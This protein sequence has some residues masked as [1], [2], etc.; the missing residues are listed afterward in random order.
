MKRVIRTDKVPQSPK[1]QSQV[2]S[3]DHFIFLSGH[4]ATDYESGIA[5]EVAVDPN[6]PYC[7]SPPMVRQTGY[8]LRNMGAV[9][10]AAG[11]GFENLIRIEQFMV[12]KDQSPWYPIARRAVMDPQ[13]PTST[14]V[15]A[16]GLE[17]PDAIIVCDGIAINPDSGWKKET[18][19]IDFIPKSITGYPAAQSYGPF[20][21]VPGMVPTDFKTGIAPEAKSDSNFW[22]HSP[23]KQQAEFILGSKAKLYGE[24]G[25]SL[26]DVVQASVYLTHM[27]DLP[28]LDYVWRQFFPENPPARTVFPCDG[29]SVLGAQI[30]VSTF[31]LR[32]GGGLPR[33]NIVAKS[34]PAPLFHE[35]HAVKAGPYLFI[36]GQLAADG[37]GLVEEAWRNPKIPWY[38]SPIK[39]E[40]KNIL[41]NVEA[42]CEE[43]GGSLSDVV[44][45]QSV[46]LDMKDLH[47]AF[48]VW[49]EAF[50][51]DPPTNMSAEVSGPM[52]VPGCRSIWSLAAYI[53]E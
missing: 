1:P 14:R 25:L 10:E 42:I 47:P 45:S 30:E 15:C 19:D 26:Q 2:I 27:E 7:G 5:P 17:V 50:P 41:K 11:A 39:S 51:A 35:P 23:I 31:A 48:E 6:L 8:M 49:G 18:H 16:K 44:R 20:V 43:A 21:F 52:P 24:L 29:L 13:H 34:I 53:P 46:F 40:V 28:G 12:G 22:I 37:G 32:P 33:R 36:S 3:T 4:L 9:L 38:T